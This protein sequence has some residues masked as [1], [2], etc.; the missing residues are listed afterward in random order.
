MKQDAYPM[1]RA[2]RCSAKSKRTGLPCRSPAVRGWAVCRM[3]G[4]GGGAN[5]GKAHPNYQ[6]GERSRESAA[7]R[8]FVNALAREGR[9]TSQRL[10]DD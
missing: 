4:A 2:P 6:H 9:D 10:T 7:I 3:H 1:H 5:P 8:A